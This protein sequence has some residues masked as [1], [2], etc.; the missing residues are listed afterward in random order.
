[1][2][3][4]ANNFDL[5]FGDLFIIIPDGTVK[6][7]S[8]VYISYKKEACYTD[9]HD[10][11]E[12]VPNY[13]EYP[14]R[15]ESISEKFSSDDAYELVRAALVGYGLDRVNYGKESWNPLG[16]YISRGD[17]VLIKPNLVMDHNENNKVQTSGLECLI[18]HTSV[19]RAVCDY[20]II[21]LKGTGRV[22]IADAP[23]QGCDFEK[24][25]SE[26]G[27][28]KLI[29]FYKKNKVK[30]ELKD[31]RQYQSTFNK[32]KVIVERKDI[33]STG[34]IVHLGEKSVHK[35]E[36]R[37]EYQVSDYEKKDT[38]AFHHGSTHDYEV[39][40]TMLKADVIINLPKPKTHRL[41]GITAAMKNM[42]GI[43][44]NKASLPHR[45][46][47][48][49]LEGGD[50]YNKKSLLK[51]VADKALTYKIRAEKKER[52][53]L[54]T[55]YRYVYGV[56]LVLGRW[57]SQ[58]RSYIGSWYGNDTIWR[59]VCDLNYIVNYADKD[60]I[61]RDTV[62]RKQ[63]NIGD[64]I[65]AGQ[66]N[67]PVSPSPKELG[68]VL[69]SDNAEM[70]DM[71]VCSLMGFDY[72]KIPILKAIYNEKKQGE[73]GHIMILSNI[74]ALNGELNSLSFPKKW[75]FV[76]YDT[77]KGHIEKDG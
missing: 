63:I 18:T 26:C 27:L 70:F 30:V 41:A 65:I 2:S 67:G 61:I 69:I 21:A 1:M 6:M 33:D 57:I 53:G 48:S 15:R 77:W 56:N 71:T 64:M 17:T 73:L 45:V 7:K 23:M 20:C 19:I 28:N 35:K 43:T 14:F 59:T 60:G 8:K 5:R 51:K 39:S 55:F 25:V 37:L 24:L 36:R 22:I 11:M 13:P 74:E 68:I 34:V 16:E 66:G 10:V 75:R 44:Y 40:A 12:Y 50:A 52:F 49:S 54:A 58:D 4:L 29:D 47:G 3:Y 42:V 38:Q 9:Y 76:P 62:Q 46:A 31:L 72:K 32:N